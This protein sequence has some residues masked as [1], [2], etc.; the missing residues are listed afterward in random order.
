MLF[1]LN[2]NIELLN[3]QCLL[4]LGWRKKEMDAAI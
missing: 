1:H 4:I 3:R 2:L